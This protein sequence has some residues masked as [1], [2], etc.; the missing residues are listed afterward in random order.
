MDLADLIRLFSMLVVLTLVML[1]H[2]TNVNYSSFSRSNEKHVLILEANQRLSYFIRWLEKS[3]DPSIQNDPI[4]QRL[5]QR[6]RRKGTYVRAIPP[7][8][9]VAAF[10]KDKGDELTLC[11]PHDQREHKNIDTVMFVLTHELAHMASESWQHNREFKAN[12][13]RLLRLAVRAKI[14]KFQ[15]FSSATPGSFCGTA[16]KHTPPLA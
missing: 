4:V 7:H 3:R 1:R 12:F 15:N 10:T 11:I 2:R 8:L 14:Y 9:G 6:W 16:I 5:V 13:Q